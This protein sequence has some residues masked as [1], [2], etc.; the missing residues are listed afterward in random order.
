MPPSL[1]RSRMSIGA[2]VMVG[3][4]SAGNVLYCIMDG[5]FEIQGASWSV[6]L[7]RNC[8]NNNSVWWKWND[9][10]YVENSYVFLKLI[11]LFIFTKPKKTTDISGRL[12]CSSVKLFSTNIQYVSCCSSRKATSSFQFPLLNSYSSNISCE[13]NSKRLLLEGSWENTSNLAHTSS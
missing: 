13:Q 2:R 12:M 9:L 5:E 10:K 7:L 4:P 3:G 6:F 1:L 11:L 8:L